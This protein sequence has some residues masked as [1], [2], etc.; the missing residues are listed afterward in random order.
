MSKLNKN[1][2]IKKKLFFTILAL[3]IGIIAFWKFSNPAVASWWDD[4]WAF[5]KSIAITAHTASENNVY[6]NLTGANDL[7]TSD[8]TRFQTDCGD[9]RFTKENGELLP[10]YVVSGCGTASTVVHVNFDTF[11]AGAQTIYVYYGN[12]SAADG[13][14]L[15][16]FSTEASNYTIGSQGSEEKTPGIIAYWQFDEGQGISVKDS[17]PNSANATLAAGDGTAPT[18]TT[19]PTYNSSTGAPDTGDGADGACTVSS[20]TNINTASCAGRGTADA[21]NFSST[22]DTSAASTSIKLSA[23]S[24]GLAVG[25]EILI[26][27]LKGTAAVPSDAGEFETKTITSITT[28]TNPDDTLNFASGLTNAYAG[29]T[30]KIMVQRVP[31]YTTVT[32][33][34]GQTMTAAAFDGTKNGVIFFR[35]TGA[36]TVTGS[37]SMSGKGFT[38]GA[39]QTAHVSKGGN[40]G[41]TYNGTGG[42]GGNAAVN[43]TSGQGG[44]GGAGALCQASDKNGCYQWATGGT[45]TTGGA[46]G[47]GGGHYSAAGGGGGYGTIGTGGGSYDGNYNGSPGSGTTGGNGASS[48]SNNIAGGGGGG[49]TYGTATLSTLFMGSGGASGATYSQAGDS[50]AGG[51]GGG[52]ISINGATIT[53]TGSVVSNGAAG[54]N[55]VNDNASGGGGAGGSVAINGLT[56]ALGSSLVTATGGGGGTVWTTGGAGGDG[57]IAV[58]SG[59]NSPTWKSEEWCISGKCLFFDGTSSNIKVANAIN[60]IQ[61]ISMWVKPTSLTTGALIDLDG[62]T[63]K[64]TFSNGTLSTSGFTGT[65][66]FYVNGKVSSTLTIDTW[67]YVTV[68]TT[69]GFNSTSS[70]TIAKSSSTYLQGFIDDVKIYNY[71]KTAAQIATD[72]QKVQSNMGSGEV[73]GNKL[74]DPLSTGLLGYWKMDELSGT[75]TVSDSYRSHTGT[76]TSST[77]VTTGKFGNARSFNGSQYISVTHNSSLSPSAITISAWVYTTSQPG[78]GTSYQFVEKSANDSYRYRVNAGGTIGVFDQGCGISCLSSPGNIPLNQW[79]HVVYTGDSTGLKMYLNGSLVASNSTAY[80]GGAANTNNLLIGGSYFG[81][82]EYMIGNID[83]V[84]LYNRSLSATEVTALYNWTPQANEAPG[85]VGAWDFEEATG[86]TLIDNSTNGYN[87]TWSGTASHYTT[88]KYGKAGNFNS[89]TVDYVDMGDVLDANTTNKITLEAWIKTPSPTD[90]FPMIVTKSGASDNGYEFRF[91]STN[92]KLQV[93]YGGTTPTNLVGNTVLAANTWYH[94]TTTYDGVTAKIY[95]NGVL[96]NS[97]AMTGT[98]TANTEHLLIGA[99]YESGTP[100]YFYT[101]QIDAVRIYDYARSA[102]QIVSDM[103]A[104]HPAVG[105]P[106]GSAVGYWK[107]DEGADNR[108]SAGVND[109]C[110]SGS[111]GNALDGAESN[112]AVPATT[113]SGWTNSGKFNK[114]MIFDGSDDQIQITET[115]PLRFTTSTPYSFSSWVK[116]DSI[117]AANGYEIIG[118]RACAVRTAIFVNTA[119]K[120]DFNIDATSGG[121][122]DPLS[123]T[124]LTTGAWY[125]IVGTYDGTT[126]KVYV[127]GKQEGSQAIQGSGNIYAGNPYFIGGSTYT[128][129]TSQNW[130]LDGTIDEVKIYNY[131][132]TADEVKADFN[133]GQSLQL[134]GGGNNSTY[135]P[136]AANQE[137]CVPGDT[138]SCAAP[139]GEWKMEEGTGQTTADTSSNGNTGTFGV[140]S[141]VSTDD[142]I[143]AKG[144]IGKAT[145]FDGSND[146]ISVAHS[147]NL[148]PTGDYTLQAWIKTSSTNNHQ[149]VIAKFN[150][151][152]PYPGYILSIGDYASATGKVSLWVGDWASSYF[153]GNTS[154]N[155]GNWH[156]IVGVL[157]GTAVRIYVDGKLDNSGTRSPSRA[158][159]QGLTIGT[160]Y[161]NGGVL[162]WFFNGSIDQVRVYNYARTAAQIAWDYNKGKPIGHWKL[163]ECQGN[164]AYDSSGNSNTG[165][166]TIGA[167]GENT[168]G[169]C[170]ISSTAWGDG[171][172]GKRNASLKFD[173]TDDILS[174]A[175]MPLAW[176][177]T[178]PFSYGGWMKFANTTTGYI[179]SSSVSPGAGNLLTDI[180][181]DAYTSGR[182]T[183]EVG[184]SGTGF[185]HIESSIPYVTGS[186]E[187][188]FVTYNGANNMKLYRNGIQVSSGTYTNGSAASNGNGF[189][190]MYANNSTNYVN[191]QLDDVKVFNYA[192]T[193]TQVKDIYNGGAI[194]YGPTTGS[195]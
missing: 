54:G 169:T 176:T 121:S 114:A 100:A 7:D 125:H 75:T 164:Q 86:T 44:G 159:T 11:P 168:L 16:D 70:L 107:F 166:I 39:A 69:N 17:S 143:W 91:N 21:I 59:G 189:Y 34:S 195:P 81:T 115:A 185:T 108:C 55:G 90:N 118:N 134:G 47:G 117:P 124:V 12:S 173:G 98:I 99:R 163:D 172:T 68:T 171:A 87:G 24:T 66:T 77:N 129:G 63:H 28:T 160:R 186:W 6:I 78:V 4:N 15:T 151:T 103:N 36:V 181:K 147:S 149:P 178:T 50:G 167:S 94:V 144:K 67:Q 180:N 112:M 13:F 111:G 96:D 148:T 46:G 89:A 30:Q 131:A 53:I 27:N 9:L 128:C 45:G 80:S 145:S 126:A 158:N 193:A 29:T 116:L 191:G 57:R 155:D 104:G 65:T 79:N 43:G 161:D 1:F 3:C 162:P 153:N 74:I 72:L 10:Y 32:V 49:G 105:S 109:A 110:N 52:I 177:S 8:T 71:A 152:N 182:V 102:S 38:G 156:H 20:D 127:N 141:G 2:R 64:I 35:A 154:V 88:G 23:T 62:G 184:K 122:T 76:S 40:G 22:V 188:Y 183:F 73:L 26:I 85:P 58:G 18:G 82:A 14:N 83:E 194:F 37:I 5:R 139:V 101:G 132:L 192:L 179:L 25:D 97:V 190:M 187:H 133:R 33:N 19:N 123:T 92:G 136:Q 140:N 51:A 106:I 31:N 175:S 137:Y 174:V 157:N 42:N 150:A 170:S 60:G 135:Q 130:H 93:I 113:A 48:N 142:P 95:L 61:T 146:Y 138:T 84:R 120:I 41:T 56:I 165:T 119:G